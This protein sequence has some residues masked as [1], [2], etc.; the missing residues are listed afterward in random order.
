MFSGGQPGPGRK[1]RDLHEPNGG[2]DVQ[3]PCYDRCRARD[4]VTRIARIRSRASWRSDERAIEIQQCG[5]YRELGAS[6]ASSAGADSRIRD[7]GIL[8]LFGENLGAK[9]LR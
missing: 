7:Y 9:A 3:E 1:R 5:P 4:L 2:S 6:A 8:L